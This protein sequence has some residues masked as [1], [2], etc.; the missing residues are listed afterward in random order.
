MNV[1]SERDMF[2]VGLKRICRNLIIRTIIIL[3]TNLGE[4]WIS[5]SYTYNKQKKVAV[6][7]GPLDYGH[8]IH[9]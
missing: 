8:T 2:L 4:F 9:E 7:H 6:L 1:L 5:V 3:S